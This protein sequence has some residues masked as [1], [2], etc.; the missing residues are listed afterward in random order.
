FPSVINHHDMYSYSYW[1]DC[2]NGTAI[3]KNMDNSK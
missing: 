3:P 1:M 2:P